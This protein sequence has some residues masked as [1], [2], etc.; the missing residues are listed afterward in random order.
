MPELETPIRGTLHD[1]TGGVRLKLDRKMDSGGTLEEELTSHIRETMDVELR[2]QKGIVKNL[3]KWQKYYKGVRDEKGYPYEGTA[4]VAIPV[5]RSD[6]DAI[7][8]RI[9]DALTNKRKNFLM[10]P[11]GVADESKK[12]YFKTLETA[13]E[14]YLRN[15]LNFRER[16]RPAVLQGVKT[17][18]GILRLVYETKN[19]CYYRYANAQDLEDPSVDKYKPES[20]DLMVKETSLVFRGPNVYPVPRE[21]FIISSDATS[22]KNAYMVGMAFTLRKP[23]LILRGK[24]DIYIKANV[25]KCTPQYTVDETKQ[26]RAEAHGGHIEKTKYEEPYKLWELWFSF[27]VDNDGEEDDIVVTWNHESGVIL[28][29][30]YNPMFYG[31]RPFADLRGNQIEYTYDG[32][33]VCEILEAIQEEIDAIH[34]LRLD[35]LAQINLPVTLVRQG[36]GLKDFKLTPGKTWVI[37]ENLEEAI[38]IINF[39]DVYFSLDREED[40]LVA[41]GDR[42]V[43]ITQNVLGNSTAE[44]P[45]AKETLINVEEANK[46]FKSWTESFRGGLLEL[47][48]MLLEMFA[49]Y[50]PSYTYTDESGKS[51]SVPMPMGNIRDLLDL[52]LEV[53]SEQMNMEVRREM[54]IAKYQILSDYMTKMAGMVQAFVDPMQNSEMKKFILEVNNIGSTVLNAVMEDFDERSPEA[55][56]PDMNKILNVEQ[57]IMNSPDIQMMLQQQQGINPVQPGQGAQ[58]PNQNPQGP[59][60]QPA[61]PGGMNGPAQAVPPQ[62]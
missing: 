39:P 23:Q 48:Y 55:I 16:I 10:K 2:N 14:H 22:I 43:G 35:R 11:K 52:D 34:N 7:F 18:T 28:N 36:L 5:T 41:Y 8:V 6:A 31:Y 42:S 50:Q 45:V 29:A 56:V 38:R 59:A 4:N 1:W 25:E 58:A 53:S 44:R 40:R 61:P 21:D 54:N 33:G 60:P 17:G 37:D 32:E 62:G 15:V 51:M 26:D 19:Q 46:K 27:D 30:I 13:F 49:Q 24:K 12:A 57:D 47:G 9:Y 3:R 20:G